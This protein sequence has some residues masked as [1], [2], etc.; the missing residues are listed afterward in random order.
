MKN[1]E[2]KTVRGL[3]IYR[4]VDEHSR[5]P[6][7]IYQKDAASPTL[8]LRCKGLCRDVDLKTS[9]IST[10]RLNAEYYLMNAAKARIAKLEAFVSGLREDTGKLIDEI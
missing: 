8:Y 3:K 9:C 2:K 4:Y 7:E 1:T 5:I 6:F 10:A